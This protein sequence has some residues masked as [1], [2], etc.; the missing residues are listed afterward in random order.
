MFYYI[1]FFTNGSTLQLCLKNKIDLHTLRGNVL[2]FDDV[3]INLDNVNFIKENN[4]KLPKTI[5]VY[6]FKTNND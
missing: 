6:E 1:I 2:I 3:F 4:K 5:E